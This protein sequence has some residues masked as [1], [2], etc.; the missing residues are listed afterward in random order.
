MGGLEVTSVT[1]FTDRGTYPHDLGALHH[2][3]CLLSSSLH[4]SGFSSSEPHKFGSQ[5][6]PLLGSRPSRLSHELTS[7][8]LQGGPLPL[9]AGSEIWPGFV[10]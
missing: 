1:D 10:E 2:R 8:R 5:V 4:L 9:A 7:P 6:T 3:M